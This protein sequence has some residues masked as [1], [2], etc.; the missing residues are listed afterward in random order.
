M[1][2]GVSNR[3]SCF[4][5]WRSDDF[6]SK[7]GS[8]PMSLWM[9]EEAAGPSCFCALNRQFNIVESQAS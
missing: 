8:A 5:V 9:S 3:L 2:D 4:K 1:W 7:N 6:E